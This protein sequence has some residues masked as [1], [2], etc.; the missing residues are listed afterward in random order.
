MRFNPAVSQLG[1]P[2]IPQAASWTNHY[3]GRYG[4]VMDMSQAVPDFPA[5]S[6]VLDQLSAHAGAVVSAGYGC[7]EGEA[8]LRAT[9]ATHISDVYSQNITNKNIHIT[10]GCNQAFVAS[11][12]ALA[13]SG[14]TVVMSNPCYFNHES[15]A[16]MLG[17][18]VKYV[19]CLAENNFQPTLLALE[20]CID[21]TVRVMALVSPN[22]PTGAIY[23]PQTLREIFW[24]CQQH[25]IWL[26]LDETY[27]D[28]MNLASR[29]IEEDS[30]SQLAETS[31]KSAC[32]PHDLFGQSDWQD[33]FIQLYSFSKSMSIPG[34]RLGAI[35]AGTD[36][37]DMIA[38]VMDNIQICAP[39]AAQLAIA[40][41]LLSIQDWI[42][43]NAAT[44]ALRSET[45]RSV[46]NRFPDWKIQSAGAY[47]AYVEHPFPDRSSLAVAKML[48]E[49]YGV[50]TLPGSFFGNRQDRYLRLA[51]ANVDIETI[52]LLADRF[53]FINQQETQTSS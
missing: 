16:Q 35:T 20:A 43:D 18:N 8:T 14:D 3:D 7:I 36:A 12:I 34:H 13:G 47:F 11:L 15:T 51:F 25:G 52:R 29:T 5:H 28:F 19:E 41:R 53:E 39:R 1:V 50:L 45:F 49:D 48:A 17:I 2:A 9:Y 26:V 27:R 23:S 22:N 10:S 40:S 21:D 6:S 33:T 31:G 46:M 32:T 38:R 37:I 30:M 4:N 42:A 24:L 44:I